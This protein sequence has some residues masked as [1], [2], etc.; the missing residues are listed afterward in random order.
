MNVFEIG[1]ARTQDQD[2]LGIF[3]TNSNSQFFNQI[4]PLR[5][6]QVYFPQIYNLCIQKPAYAM[7]MKIKF[8]EDYFNW[9][10]VPIPIFS[11]LRKCLLLCITLLSALGFLLTILIWFPPQPC[12]PVHLPLPYTD[13]GFSLGKKDCMDLIVTHL[14]RSWKL[15]KGWV[16]PLRT[17]WGKE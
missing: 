16:W 14:R 10:V 8:S 17:A 15:T 9:Y 7:S 13:I 2:D 6:E 12:L 1:L 11:S 3:L 4:S 5:A